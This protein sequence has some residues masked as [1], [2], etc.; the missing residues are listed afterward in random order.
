MCD[1]CIEIDK[2]IGHLRDLATRVLDQTTTDGIAKLIEELL[3][4]KL[5]L[6]PDDEE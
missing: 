4:Q 3:D 2:K 5:K 1:K 6:H